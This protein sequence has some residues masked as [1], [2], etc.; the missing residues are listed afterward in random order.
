MIHAQKKMLTDAEA[1]VFK[2]YNE[3]R[4]CIPKDYEDTISEYVSRVSRIPDVHAIYQIGSITAPGIS[5]IDLL[6]V[7]NDKLTFSSPKEYLPHDSSK[8]C[9]LF[10][11]PPILVPISL[12]KNICMIYPIFDIKKIYGE[13]FEISAP[14]RDKLS[15][16]IS[17][18]LND[19]I[20]LFYPVEFI[21]VL[22]SGKGD[23][24]HLLLRL[25]GVKHSISLY[26]TLRVGEIPPEWDSFIEETTELRQNWFT[27]KEKSRNKLLL[28]LLQEAVY[29]SVDLVDK[30]SNYISNAYPAPKTN[31]EHIE[32]RVFSELGFYTIFTYKWDKQEALKQMIYFSNKTGIRI[33]ILPMVYYFQLLQYSKNKGPMSEHI[34]KNMRIEEVNKEAHYSWHHENY[35]TEILM[36]E[37]CNFLNEHASFFIR[38]K[39]SFGCFVGFF[40]LNLAPSTKAKYGGQ[41]YIK[42]KRAAVNNKLKKLG[43]YCDD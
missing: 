43:A 13:N 25:N 22:V 41:I 39:I 27:L 6:V 1:S 24:R 37:R 2:F 36:N 18:I 9:Y 29:L 21:S 30:F 14:Q 20:I 15:P 28:N 12:I 19:F 32:Y 17:A 11:H 7:L 35:E 10:I 4:K 31:C 34:R 33:S 3:P 40:G 16:T 5:D 23:V 8:G 38:N 26:K 42:L